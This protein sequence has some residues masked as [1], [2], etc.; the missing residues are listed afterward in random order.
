MTCPKS[1]NRTVAAPSVVSSPHVLLGQCSLSWHGSV[2]SPCFVPPYRTVNRHCL[3][4]PV[5]TNPD[6]PSHPAPCFTH[7]PSISPRSAPLLASP[8]PPP[9]GQCP[10]P[11]PNRQS[12][13]PASAQPLTSRPGP[14]WYSGA[15]VRSCSSPPRR[16]RRRRRCCA[17]YAAN[18]DAL[19]LHGIRFFC[20][21][22]EYGSGA[23]PDRRD[24]AP[25]LDELWPAARGIRV[26]HDQPRPRGHRQSLNVPGGGVLDG[27]RSAVASDAAL[28]G[29]TGAVL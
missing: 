24:I 28:T 2:G 26:G 1:L 16:V 19:S 6:P 27:S 25:V 29:H 23:A 13:D 18:N 17:A 7:P 14:V 15:A 3:A 8:L 9:F 21:G 5:V 12:L 22:E 10:P 4:A 20:C 11:P